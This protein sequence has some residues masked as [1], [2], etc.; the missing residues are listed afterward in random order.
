MHWFRKQPLVG[1]VRTMVGFP[2]IATAPC[3]FFGPIGIL[4]ALGI[5][6][7]YL[8]TYVLTTAFA[9][10]LDQTHTRTSS[11]TAGATSGR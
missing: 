8:L 11:I 9:E 10:L 6:G 3:L 2:A 5:E 4:Y 7:L 1:G